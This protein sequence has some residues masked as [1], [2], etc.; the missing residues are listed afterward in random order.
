MKTPPHLPTPLLHLR[1]EMWV[2]GSEIP[3]AAEKR[4]QS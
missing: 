4:R 2:L 3:L 1:L